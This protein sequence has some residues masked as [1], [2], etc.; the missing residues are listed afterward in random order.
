MSEDL[1]NDAYNL[2]KGVDLYFTNNN[3]TTEVLQSNIKNLIERIEGTSP[4]VEYHNFDLVHKDILHHLFWFTRAKTE[5]MKNYIRGK[6]IDVLRAIKVL[7]GKVV[8][9][10]GSYYL[11]PEYRKFLH[12]NVYYVYDRN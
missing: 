4:L 5:Y 1:L 12:Y 9:I 7:H 3:I 11:T 2:L 6:N 10:D 8:T